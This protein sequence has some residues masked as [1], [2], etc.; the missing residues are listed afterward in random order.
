MGGRDEVQVD[1]E[2]RRF[3]LLPQRDLPV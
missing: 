1:T 2:Q 3:R